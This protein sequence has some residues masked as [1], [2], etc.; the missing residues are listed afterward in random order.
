MKRVYS[1]IAD[2]LKCE[3]PEK[4]LAALVAE[5]TKFEKTYTPKIEKAFQ[6]EIE[7]R[8]GARDR[9]YKTL[10][11]PNYDW[12]SIERLAVLGGTTEDE[13][14]EILVQDPKVVFG[15]SKRNGKRIAQLKKREG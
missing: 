3:V 13:V 12:R 11:D 14:L 15:K 4:N 6:A 5:V 9:I 1:L 2:K 8:T 7:K 10:A